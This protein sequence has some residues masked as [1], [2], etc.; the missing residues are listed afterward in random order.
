MINIQVFAY[1]YLDLLASISLPLTFLKVCLKLFLQ[2]LFH[3]AKFHE[4][5]SAVVVPAS[6]FSLNARNRV[7]FSHSAKSI[8]SNISQEKCNKKKKFLE[9]SII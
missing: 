4:I 3:R 2:I 7:I 9:F 8:L 5:P 1:W 6:K